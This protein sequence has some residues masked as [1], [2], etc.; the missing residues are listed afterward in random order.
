MI[1][2]LEA[3]LLSI[4]SF[5]IGLTIIIQQMKIL[6]SRDMG[7]LGQYMLLLIYCAPIMIIIIGFHFLFAFYFKNYKWIFQFIDLVM[8][9]LIIYYITYRFF[10]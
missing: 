2:F 6:G 7:G 10:L 1:K 5:I 4:I 3:L 8:G 9:A